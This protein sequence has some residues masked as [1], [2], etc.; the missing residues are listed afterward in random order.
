[1]YIAHHQQL[2]GKQSFSVQKKRA[3]DGQTCK[4]SL[5]S[6]NSLAWIVSFIGASAA[7]RTATCCYSNIGSPG[8]TSSIHLG[9]SSSS[10][11]FHSQ[12]KRQLLVSGRINA[13]QLTVLHQISP[14][15]PPDAVNA[16]LQCHLQPDSTHNRCKKSNSIV[17][18]FSNNTPASKG[19]LAM[20][21]FRQCPQRAGQLAKN[22]PLDWMKN[23]ELKKL[24]RKTRYSLVSFLS[25]VLLLTV[26]PPVPRHL[27]KWG[28]GNVPLSLW[29]RRHCPQ[30]LSCVDGELYQF[31]TG[32]GAPDNNHAHIS[33]SGTQ[34]D[35]HTQK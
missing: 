18:K 21:A 5:N 17:S 29:S 10:I 2:I 31:L 16:T 9:N 4:S 3:K 7:E 35:T 26:P 15:P 19:R 25:T 13:D 27:K 14:P 33:T 23:V 22:G 30:S 1:M 12:A 32:F 11:E 24:F 20:W 34:I 6:S 28:R 8:W